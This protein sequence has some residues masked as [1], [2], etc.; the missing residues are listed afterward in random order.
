MFVLEALNHGFSLEGASHDLKGDREVLLKAVKQDGTSIIR[1]HSFLIGAA[2][3]GQRNTTEIVLEAVSSAESALQY[4]A[5]D[6]LALQDARAALRDDAEVALCAVSQCDGA[7]RLVGEALLQERR[8]VMLALR[9]D[10]CT[11]ST[12]PMPSA[13]TARSSSRR[14]CWTTWRSAT[15]RRGSG[16][17]ASGSGGRRAGRQHRPVRPAAPPPQPRSPCCS[18]R[19][20]RRPAAEAAGP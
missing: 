16:A 8:L 6:G 19:R 4:A 11:S 1:L 12:R 17:G 15:P 5:L 9:G 13:L 3:R 18:Q 7:L 14:S 10:G 2:Q 20:R